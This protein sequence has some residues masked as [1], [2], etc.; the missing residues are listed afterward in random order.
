MISVTQN[1]L[2]KK[3]NDFGMLQKNIKN[4]IDYTI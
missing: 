1:Q 3:R 4:I 2:Q